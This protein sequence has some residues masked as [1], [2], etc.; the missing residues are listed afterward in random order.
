MCLKYN[1]LLYFSVFNMFMYFI[2]LISGGH[3]SLPGWKVLHPSL[4]SPPQIG[5]SVSWTLTS[6]WW[7]LYYLAQRDTPDSSCPSQALCLEAAAS[8]RHPGSF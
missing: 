3:S 7:L 1:L 5:A 4:G 2:Y 8:V 6:L